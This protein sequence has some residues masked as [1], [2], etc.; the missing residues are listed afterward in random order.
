MALNDPDETRPRY[1]RLRQ[2]GEGSMGVV[3]EAEDT[4]QG[5]KVAQKR[6]RGE[7]AELLYRLKREFRSLVGLCHRNLVQ[8]YELGADEAG[9]FFTM[10]L[11][12]GVDFLTHCRGEAANATQHGANVASP[13]AATSAPVYEPER[14][15][16][17]LAGLVRG[18]HA[19]HAH[20]MVHRDIKPSNVMVARNGRVVLIDFGLVSKQ[21]EAELQA[22]RS[23]LLGTSAYLAPEQLEA[24][25]AAGFA[26]DYYAVGVMLFEV[27]AGR[28]PFE[29]TLF[30]VLQHKLEQEA[31]DV[32]QF[33]A[34]VP[35]HLARLC[36]S[37]LLRDPARRAGTRDMLEWL[38]E[39]LQ[40]PLGDG[41]VTRSP[42]PL[43]GRSTELAR[44]EHALGEVMAGA[45]RVVLVRG[46][47]GIGKTALI[48]DFLEHVAS[49]VPN[50]LVLSTSCYE[51][52]S[53]PYKAVDGL[54]DQLSE[55]WRRLPLAEAMYLLPREPEFL[56]RAFPV[57][58]RVQAICDKVATPRPLAAHETL[59]RSL[60]ACRETFQRLGRRGPLVLAL[61]D[62][63]WADPDSA[64]LL[65]YLI[66]PVDAPGIL[67]ILA[68]RSSGS[69]EPLDTA[70]EALLK[71]ALSI[72]LLP[73]HAEHMTA[74][75]AAILGPD[76]AALADELTREAGGSP[77]L[78]ST[79]ARFAR[80]NPG[81]RHLDLKAM[82][83]ERLNALPERSRTLLQFIALDGGPLTPTL[84]ARALAVDAGSI[85][86]AL[87]ELEALDLV[88]GVAG[89]KGRRVEPYHDRIRDSVLCTIEQGQRQALHQAL[90]RALEQEPTPDS[91]ACARHFLGA[92]DHAN[93]RFY[94]RDAA[95]QA[96]R[97]LAFMHAAEHYRLCLEL[98]P[99]DSE[100]ARGL[101][102]DLANALSHAGR[103]P[104][105][106]E[107]YLAA[108][109]LSSADDR[110]TCEQR[111][112]EEYLRA[113]YP[114]LGLET[115][116]VVL[117]QVG[118]DYPKSTARALLGGL[119]EH[120]LARALKG[121]SRQ[122][123]S[124]DPA[125]LRRIDVARTVAN[126][127]SF[128]EP[129]VTFYYQ[130][131]HLRLALQA[132]EPFRLCRALCMEATY[133]SLGGTLDD[134][135][136]ALL[137]EAH[138]LAAQMK[139]PDAHGTVLLHAG[140]VA[141]Y[142]ADWQGA[143]ER[144][145]NATE[146]L[147]R[148]PGGNHWE[149]S[150]SLLYILLSLQTRG[151]VRE[152]RRRLHRELAQAEARGDMFT[153][154]ILRASVSHLV[155][156]ADDE[157][158]RI[159]D[160]LGTVMPMWAEKEFSVPRYWELL[161]LT[162]RD[163]YLGEAERAFERFEPWPGKLARSLPMRVQVTRVK[164]RHARGRAA[165]ALV[166]AGQPSRVGAV[167]REIAALESEGVGWALGLA[168]SLR[169]GV[170]WFRGD[171]DTC[172]GALRLAER[173][174]SQAELWLD[175]WSLNRWRAQLDDDATS[176]DLA[177]QS[178]S[179]FTQHGIRNPDALTRVHAPAF[180]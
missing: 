140:M 21:V 110:L 148:S 154:T 139:E 96:E 155:R 136:R 162:N 177:A 164:V 44:L 80:S 170:A 93:A 37:L 159:G 95:K 56:V 174:L 35:E 145:S 85:V 72:E 48:R 69:N 5:R 126:C 46:A 171:R 97:Q 59:R 102:R 158:G 146:M 111:A 82:L 101:R 77:F 54:M 73:I 42:S 98:S 24:D 64:R 11:V 27:L 83:V 45:C 178:T 90:A 74:L 6:I 26:S 142:R 13:A 51:A 84:L 141:Y 109:Q 61:D 107:Q 160:D 132:A 134:R 55:F 114:K 133:R 34:D 131:R 50:A 100:A 115:L 130:G 67:L 163:L 58:S 135:T 29:G 94:A 112:A 25:G 4:E 99:L 129:A 175:A 138:A 172:L 156:L 180:K 68:G 8:L 2:L 120:A 86:Q 127:L 152:L 41:H 117:H 62:I 88:R 169:A 30:E 75:V 161:S 105:A 167:E 70:L 123:T 16:A 66:D 39:E 122:A 89:T 125:L 149:L 166:V 76:A 52:E 18:L 63:Q 150:N 147:E 65:G 106:A 7:N 79:L 38:G 119:L 53:I 32:R 87:H 108:A 71:T 151:D 153:L 91:G 49:D 157:P 10:E 12:D 121:R 43:L 33:A 104:L 92:G 1:R 81:L 173:Q 60:A 165:L 116:A 118:L 168:S 14:L 22:S 36:G 57:L 40:P 9:V 20:G 176:P 124:H 19:L 3:F 179:W 128:L 78:G 23:Q 28:R 143:Y 144:C 113:G 15:R 31:P 103:G 47:S 17:A 137:T